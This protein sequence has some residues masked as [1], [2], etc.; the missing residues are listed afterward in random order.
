MRR[1][2]QYLAVSFLGFLSFS[3]NA[4]ASD[5]PRFDGVYIETK[6]GRF[7]QLQRARLQDRVLCQGRGIN[8]RELERFYV[9]PESVIANSPNVASGTIESVFV[10]SRSERLDFILFAARLRD[11][12]SY[13]EVT[14]G[15]NIHIG[16]PIYEQ[17]GANCLS[18]ERASVESYESAIISSGCGI[19]S[20]R[21]NLLN[22]SAN[23]WQYFEGDRAR[24]TR[25]L[26]P[27]LNDCDSRTNSLSP[28][29]IV[30]TNESHYFVAL[31]SPP[32]RPSMVECVNPDTGAILR[33]AG[34]C[35][36][37]LDPV[38]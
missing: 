13:M 35:P 17:L 2:L 26:T 11:V 21:Y 37:G 12:F 16:L 34:A 32:S 3:G 8:S 30:R 6:D 23:S 25:I 27:R 1:F 33:Y 18:A 20:Q 22:E 28:G 10:R 7:I 19:S 14:G 29:I 9:V 4:L 24:F 38:D 15:S 5:L 31:S 36:D